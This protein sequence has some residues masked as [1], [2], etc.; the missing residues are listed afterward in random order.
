MSSVAL[1]IAYKDDLRRITVDSS[2]TLQSLLNLLAE[3]VTKN[4][5]IR[6]TYLDDEA[7]KITLGTDLELREAI[8]HSLERKLTPLK[9]TIV[10]D[11]P[12]SIPA[13]SLPVINDTPVGSVSLVVHEAITCSFCEFPVTGIRYKCSLCR[14]FDL[15][16]ECE[17]LEGAH[18][19]DHPLIKIKVPLPATFQPIH[20]VMSGIHVARGEL[21]KVLEQP[22]V[23]E[24]REMV[25]DVAAQAAEAARINFNSVKE[26]LEKNL[27]VNFQQLSNQLLVK[28]NQIR[29]DVL[30]Q[31][32]KEKERVAEI[33]QEY[34]A[35]QQSTSAPVATPPP[36]SP[37][38]SS[39][40]PEP[41]AAPVA[42]PMYNNVLQQ[43][44]SM[45]FLDEDHN[46][47]IVM[48][49][50]GNLM[51]SLEELLRNA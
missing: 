2:I 51:A 4:R 11:V 40:E 48:D 49:N 27:A 13:S 45:G 12:N 38:V 31:L 37:E 21:E 14:N 50:N 1:K 46:L 3:N 9:L 7:D 28:A 47:A 36:S 19:Q 8:R 35:T 24:V 39:P 17:A 43:L 20:A 41:L 6:L 23:V 16:E 26:N 25:A 10:D 5:N 15:C 34:S 18:P 42:A 22:Q 33:Y 32:Q 30:I 29:Q 44:K